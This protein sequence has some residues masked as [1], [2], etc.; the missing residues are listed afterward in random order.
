MRNGHG[1]SKAIKVLKQKFDSAQVQEDLTKT[2]RL[3]TL[4]SLTLQ[5][6]SS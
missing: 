5:D 3:K 6:D 2:E 4:I 1:A